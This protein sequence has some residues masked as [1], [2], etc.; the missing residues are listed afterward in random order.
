MTTPPAI[1]AATAL[2]A[3]LLRALWRR[4]DWEG[5]PRRRRRNISEELRDAL[6][7]MVTSARS[8]L[9]F[10]R[11]LC[12]RFS[13]NETG[14]TFEND[15]GKEI[16][17]RPVYVL[18]PRLL[19]PAGVLEIEH[20]EADETTA[21][22]SWTAVCKAI[23][24]DALRLA[25]TESPALFAT[26]A[27]APPVDG[28]EA[29]FTPWADA[30]ASAETWTA[31][32]PGDLL[33]PRAYTAVWTLVAP[34][35]HGH[36]EKSGNVTM[37]R[38]QRVV[39]PVTGE[40]AIVPLVSGNAVRGCWRDIIMG[41]M[42]QLVGLTAQDL[43]A[44]RAHALLSG[45]T[46]EAGAD[47]DAVDVAVRRRARAV[48]PAWDLFAGVVDGQIMRGLLRV[49]D[50]ILLCRENAWMVHALLQP[51]TRD[52]AAMTLPEFTASLKPADTL[53]QLRLLTH[54]A[55]RDIEDCKGVQM[56]VN[57]EVLIPG[58]QLVHRFQLIGLDGV[59]EVAGAC[60]ADLLVEFQQDGFVGAANA[61]GLGAVGFVA[62][63]PGGSAP[64]LPPPTVYQAWVAEHRDELRA[65]LLED[66]P[67]RR[68]SAAKTAPT[69]RDAGVAPPAA[70][71][72]VKAGR[73]RRS[74]RE[75]DG[76]AAS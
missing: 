44:P 63:V 61:R 37:F 41:R 62:Y 6:V 15:E 14:G 69:G 38:R 26:F 67:G 58:V 46:I 40:I 48:C 50:V 10:T 60:M 39:S 35:A 11:M 5:I 70:K 34:M 25:V 19:V 75:G 32:V 76:G 22:V 74:G 59:S 65:W 56:L 4:V 18:I 9:E 28:E 1:H 17:A 64:P 66:R 30:S 73:R 2:M 20:P 31:E 45:G 54:H 33:T 29:L 53:T 7:P 12:Q 21:A 42:L 71:G 3:Y 27:T 68:Q 36:D 23:D 72:P 16:T 51:K 47:G 13:I 57:T 52:G 8:T 43:P 55:H 24:F 49:H